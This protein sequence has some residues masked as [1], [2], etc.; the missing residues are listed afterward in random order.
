MT[1]LARAGT[2][3]AFRRIALSAATGLLAASTVIA[4]PAAGATCSWKPV[5]SQNPPAHDDLFSVS[6]ASAS[7]V[8]AVGT[9]VATNGAR[10][11]L[12]EHWNGKAW[13]V[14]ATPDPGNGNQFNGV[15]DIS[16]SNAWAV[17]VQGTASGTKPLIAHWN[18][19]KWTQVSSPSVGGVQAYLNRVT[20]LAA[21]DL[22]AV[23]TGYTTGSGG[24]FAL[25]EHFDGK[26]WTVATSPNPGQY[27]SQL[28]G[29]SGSSATDVWANGGTFTNPSGTFVTLT[30]HWNGTAWSVVPSPNA[31]NLNNVFNAVVAITSTDAWA[32]GDY[33]TGTGST[34]DSLTEHWDGKSWKIITS[35]S[36]PTSTAL[37]GVAAASS[38]AVWIAGQITS[39]TGS[40]VMYWNGKKWAREK[41][42]VLAGS[43]QDFLNGIATVPGGSTVWA[44]GGDATSSG[45]PNQTL[46][47][48][49]SCTI[50]SYGA[51]SERAHASLF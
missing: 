15:A 21:N 45:G 19:K 11:T 10:A 46:T 38:S 49:Y 30:E 42:P 34:F 13:S 24:A 14:T 8:W 18:G 50:D 44:V 5:A 40:L 43:T 28:S 1:R 20:A 47:T 22:W 35:P 37:W 48:D 27:G 41:T 26:H 39:T 3:S 51:R 16:P 7:D 29:V 2:R 25:I 31:N 6:A 17:G 12:A 9:T 33:W 32:V 4:T 23:G 36:F